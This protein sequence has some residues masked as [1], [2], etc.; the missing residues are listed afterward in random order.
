VPSPKETLSAEELLSD[1]HAALD[2]LLKIFLAALD[3]AETPTIFERLDLFWARL[4]MHIRGE[5]LHLFPAILNR[6]EDPAQQANQSSLAAETRQAV[7]RLRADHDFSMHESAAAIKT[8]RTLKDTGHSK[9]ESHLMDEVWASIMA[10]S[11][12]L[13]SHNEVEEK[14]VYSLPAR[15]L[16]SNETTS[17]SWRAFS[18]NCRIYRRDLATGK[19][20]A[21]EI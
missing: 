20:E 11:N 12:R 15:V 4:A 5:N 14:L 9:A 3:K 18:A 1:D 17:S 6:L 13:E 19:P 10:I 16:T 21:H 2:K 7:A 8:V